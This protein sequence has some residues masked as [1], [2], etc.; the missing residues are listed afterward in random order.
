M[1][2]R[3]AANSAKAFAASHRQGGEPALE[4]PMTVTFFLERIRV[5]H[6]CVTLCAYA[7]LAGCT[8]DDAGEA[9]ATGDA[10]SPPCADVACPPGRDAVVGDVEVDSTS[11]ALDSAG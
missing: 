11:D 3:A 10:S 6:L 1:G 2:F 5:T 4:R 9:Q 7:A 8:S